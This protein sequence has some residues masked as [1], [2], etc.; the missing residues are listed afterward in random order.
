MPHSHE[1]DRFYIGHER[2]GQKEVLKEEREGCVG[3]L[4][5]SDEIGEL[6]E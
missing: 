2:R 4:P 1:K 5:M 6:L 3:N